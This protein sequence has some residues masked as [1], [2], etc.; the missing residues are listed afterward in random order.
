MHIDFKTYLPDDIL[1]K[2]DRASMAHGLEVRCPLLD[3]R[4]V[5]FAARLPSRRKI[6]DGRTKVILREA[7]ADLL[8]ADVLVRPKMGFAVPM[9]RWLRGALR[10]V[11]E[12]LVLAGGE[13]HGLF[14]ADA[15][16]TLWRQHRTGQRDRARELWGIAMFNLWY[17]RFGVAGAAGV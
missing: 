6:H 7:L 10:P 13:A 3:Q 11:V 17:R 9:H 4:L 16:Q 8:P 14:A 2:V 5:E 12:D 1:T 15:L